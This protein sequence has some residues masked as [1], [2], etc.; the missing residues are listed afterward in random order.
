MRKII[1]KE[2]GEIFDSI[3]EA[4]IACGYDKSKSNIRVALTDDKRSNRA[5]GYTWHYLESIEA[6]A[7]LRHQGGK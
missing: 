1:C 6:E 2:T 3:A 7:I 5:F 4:T